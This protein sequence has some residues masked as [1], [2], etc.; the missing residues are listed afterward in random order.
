VCCFICQIILRI[1]NHCIKKVRNIEHSWWVA[2][3]LVDPHHL[4]QPRKPWWVLP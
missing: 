2:E 1:L 3:L 4:H